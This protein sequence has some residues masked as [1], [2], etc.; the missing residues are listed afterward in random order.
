MESVVNLSRWEKI[1]EIMRIAYTLPFVMASI[2]GVAFA[3]TIRLEWLIAL[4][5]PL[6]VFFLAL[7]VNFSNDYFDHMSGVDELRFSDADNET[8]D[9]VNELFDQK[10]F[11]S[12]NSFDKGLITEKQGRVVMALIALLAIVVAIPIVL[13][14][15]TT[16]IVVG[17]IGLGLAFFYTAPPVNLGARGLGELDVFLSFSM[18]SFFSFFVI[19]QQFNLTMALIALTIGAT[20]MI[21]RLTDEAPGYECHKRM[22]EKNLCVRFGLENMIK[23]V[24]SLTVLYYAAVIVLATIQP[25]FLLLFLT[26]L[27]SVKGIKYLKNK[28]DKI[29]FWRAIPEALKFALFNQILILLILIAQTVWTSL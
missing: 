7:F 22:G 29:R 20:V 4:L 11:W 21:M 24:I 17:L 3:L 10:V 13:Y 18:I 16:A 25:V 14:A 6:D 5:I 15:G 19:V 2:V 9:Q 12:G 8:M 23:I 1:K 27:I 26:L 28:E